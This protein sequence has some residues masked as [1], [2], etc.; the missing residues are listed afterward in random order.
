[1]CGRLWIGK[2]NL[3]VTP[4]VGAATMG[5]PDGIFSTKLVVLIRNQ[6]KGAIRRRLA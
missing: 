4:L 5:G 1:M 2:E 3:H 6:Q